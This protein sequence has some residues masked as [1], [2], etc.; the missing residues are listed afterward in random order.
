MKIEQVETG[1]Q[2]VISLAGTLEAPETETAENE[3]GK[4]EQP[5]DKNAVEDAAKVVEGEI[6][7][8][9]VEGA[10]R[11][12]LNELRAMLRSLRNDNISLQTRLTAAERVQNGEFGTDG[13]NVELTELEVYQQQLEAAKQRDFSQLIAVMEVNPKYEDIG[14]VCST[15]NVSDVFDA[16]AQHRS[17]T[18]GTDFNVELLKVQ[19]EVWGTA[20]PYKLLYDTIKDNHPKYAAKQEASKQEPAKPQTAAGKS[21]KELVAAVPKAPGTIAD[22]AGNGSNATGGWTASRIDA[23]P[24][25]ELHTVPKDIYKK[26]LSGDLD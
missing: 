15:A 19:A 10:S 17:A 2:E 25:N 22:I 13:A 14:E 9:E 23:L 16:V 3:T 18:N 1:T 26:W 21:A 20:N 6:K 24:E 8:A 4:V 7:Q 12:E 11:E 5:D